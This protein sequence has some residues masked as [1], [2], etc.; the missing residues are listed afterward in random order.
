MT[1]FLILLIFLCLLGL[2]WFAGTDAPYIP[3]KYQKIKDILKLA[4][5]KKGKV[6]YELGCGDGRVVIEAAWLGATAFGI[7]QSWIRVLMSR[8]E[9]RNLS[10][11]NAKF[12]H[13]NIFKFHYP[14]ADTV[15]IYMLQPCVDLLE[16]ILKK[17]LKKGSKVITQ[18]YHFKNWKP[19]KTKD[20]FWIYQA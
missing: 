11:I 2:S 4:G 17:E 13:G 9:V 15:Y 14:D 18:R 7:E 5:V 19:I 6:F 16:Q 20:D 3:T 10:L 1:I 8:W 12:Y